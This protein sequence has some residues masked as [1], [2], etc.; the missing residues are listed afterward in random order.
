MHDSYN[1]DIRACINIIISNG[2]YYHIYTF[3]STVDKYINNRCP[4]QLIRQI[5]RD[6]TLHEIFR[7]TSSII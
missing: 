3:W 7:A 1:D 2:Y 5:T 6:I 4:N